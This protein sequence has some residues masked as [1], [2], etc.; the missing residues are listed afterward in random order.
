M[1]VRGEVYLPLDDFRRLNEERAE[2]GEPL[3]ANPRN[4]G[5]GSVRQLDP[6]V[7][8][9]RNLK[10]WVYSLGNFDAPGL[11]GNHFDSL[12][13]LREAGFPIN[14]NNRLFQSLDEV[15]DYYRHW[16]E[17]RHDLPYEAD[18]VVIKVDPFP[19]QT[20][21][22]FVGREPG[23]PSPT[24]SR[25]SGQRLDSLTSVSTWGALAA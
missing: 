18:G 13:W 12:E 24:S 1:E 22:G 7:T 6:R 16:L 20:S 3:Y 10:I 11:P 2:R 23:G 25:R 15:C 19:Y 8:A 17:N 4:T 5:A 9:S 21:L 14:P